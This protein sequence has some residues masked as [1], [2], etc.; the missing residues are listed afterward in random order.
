MAAIFVKHGCPL[1]YTVVQRYNDSDIEVFYLTT[2][3]VGKI[4]YR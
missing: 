4:I 2:L 1:G 3:S